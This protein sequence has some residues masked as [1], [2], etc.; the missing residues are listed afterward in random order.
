MHNSSYAKESVG[1]QDSVNNKTEIVLVLF[2]ISDII[3][4]LRYQINIGY[5]FHIQNC[6]NFYFEHHSSNL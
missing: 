4:S 3:R 5:L 1:S 6:I 2:P